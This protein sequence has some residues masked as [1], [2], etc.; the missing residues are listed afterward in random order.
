MKNLFIFI[1]NNNL[2]LAI[3]FFGLLLRFIVMPFSAHADMVMATFRE[4]TLVFEGKMIVSNFSELIHAG[5]LS[6]GRPLFE[7][8]LPRLVDLN[9]YPSYE[10][11]V[12]ASNV[13]AYLFL[14]KAPYL[15]FDLIF[16]YFIW[17][18]TDHRTEKK[19]L[20]AIWALNPLMIYA[21]YVWGRYEII[22]IMFAFISYFL[23]KNTENSRRNVLIFLFIGLAISTR[24]T[25]LIYLPFFIIFV[26][27]EW[28]KMI[29]YTMFS[30]LPLFITNKIIDFLRDG[31][32]SSVLAG[33]TNNFLGFFLDG[34]LGSG[35]NQISP[36]LILY[37]MVIFLYYKENNITF[38]KLINYSTIAVLVFFSTSYFHPHYLV[39]ITP[40]IMLAMIYNKKIIWSLA[41]LILS[42]Y[43]LAEAY[44]TSGVTWGLF[45]PASPDFFPNFSS[46]LQDIIYK[47]G[48]STVVSSFHTIFVFMAG[49]ICYI[50]YRQ[51]NEQ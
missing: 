39:W 36:F 8:L 50:L 2:L 43:L 42:G 47:Y 6:I 25:F 7:N 37:P 35:F 22:P 21:V 44:F 13:S 23:A 30:L 27:K 45:S 40:A 12:R 14:L 26:T 24:I 17:K 15:I 49:I 31:S 3:V 16:L 11:F 18:F 1:K 10:V 5:F 34:S 19:W 9:G 28:K 46:G 48:Q 20:V 29:G 41:L 33:S 51:R 4:L 32:T 38:K